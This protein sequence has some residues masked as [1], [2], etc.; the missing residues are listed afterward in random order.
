MQKLLEM[1]K[2]MQFFYA[3]IL[4]IYFQL[5]LNMYIKIITLSL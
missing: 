3:S 5:L 2:I 1:S 4:V